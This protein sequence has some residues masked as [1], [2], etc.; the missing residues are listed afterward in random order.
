MTLKYWPGQKRGKGEGESPLLTPGCRGDLWWLGIHTYL[1]CN[2]R[3]FLLYLEH[4]RDPRCRPLCPTDIGIS[5]DCQST[6]FFIEPLKTIALRFFSHQE[7]PFNYF[8]SPNLILLCVNFPPADTFADKLT[9]LSSNRTLQEVNKIW[10]TTLPCLYFSQ[11]TIMLN[12]LLLII[13]CSRIW[14]TF[15]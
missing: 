9:F 2:I 5:Q 1:Y 4:M 12:E 11:I 3:T 8:P 10:E 13:H 7:L 14:F 6:F 15:S